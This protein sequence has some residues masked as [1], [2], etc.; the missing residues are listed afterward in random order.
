VSRSIARLEEE[1][2]A[3][4]FQRTTR[5][6]ALTPT[7]ES[8]RQRCVGIL[9]ALE[10]AVDQVRGTKSVP[11]GLLRV[12]AGVGFGINFLAQEL[13]AFLERYPGVTVSLDL[14]SDVKDLLA[15]VDVAVRLGPMADSGLVSA[16]LRTMTRHLCV[17]PSYV[18]RR[19]TPES[20][21]DLVGHDTVEMPT[22]DGRP[23][24]WTFTKDGETK[25]IE[26]PARICVNEALAI[27]R[28]I[29]NGAGIGII[30]GYLCRPAFASGQLLQLFPEWSA[31]SIDVNIVFASKR[32][33]SAN[34]R[35]FVEFMK[36]R[37]RD[38]PPP[39]ENALRQD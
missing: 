31:P 38:G 10:A 20:L 21:D 9:A 4:L 1:L 22:A 28:L 11:H 36:E 32:E 35:A 15:D 39:G 18:D 2:G 26:I 6:V 25:K 12:T 29:M 37:H 27:Y 19:G 17:S 5:E 30:S 8:L 13:P 14:S 23:R 33:L 34:V 16:R 24:G 7:G 3:R